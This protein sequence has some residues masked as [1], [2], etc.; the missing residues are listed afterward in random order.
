[1]NER[2]QLALIVGCGFVIGL[3]APNAARLVLESWTGPYAAATDVAQ[4][5]SASNPAVAATDAL[6]PDGAAL[7]ASARAAD[8]R[9]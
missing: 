1:M 4:R 3:E 5:P 2:L 7:I 9:E 8:L 6:D